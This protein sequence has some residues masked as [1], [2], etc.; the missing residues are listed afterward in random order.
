MP[1][2]RLVKQLNGQERVSSGAVASG[3]QYS[4]VAGTNTEEPPAE[5]SRP[6]T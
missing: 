6:V 1:E 5:L 2:D 3:G 4:E